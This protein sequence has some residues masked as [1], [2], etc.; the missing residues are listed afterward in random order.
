MPEDLPNPCTTVSPVPTDDAVAHQQACRGSRSARLELDNDGTGTALA[1]A[2]RMQLNA[3]ITAPDRAG[4]RQLIGD[5]CHGLGGNGNRGSSRAECGQPDQPSGGVDDSAAVGAA[6]QRQVE[7]EVPFDGCRQRDCAIR[8]A[9]FG[10]DAR[11]RQFGRG[12]APDRQREISG[13]TAAASSNGDGSTSC[14]PNSA[15]SV[16]GSRPTSS[17]VI[18]RPSAATIPTRSPTKLHRR[19]RHIPCAGRC[20]LRVVPRHC[21]RRPHARPNP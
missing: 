2:Q 4:C 20:R 18:S 8:P 13:S 11:R 7:P 1:V 12:A 5:A 17:A 10:D 15:I 19:S 6:W 16:D 3:K 9:G 14:N 21:A